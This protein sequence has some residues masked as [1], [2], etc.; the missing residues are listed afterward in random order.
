MTSSPTRSWPTPSRPGAQIAFMNPGG[1]RADLTFANSPGG[2]APGQVT[3]GEAFAVQPFNNLVVTQTFTG[4]QIKDVLEQQFA[5]LRGADVAADPAGVGRVHVHLRRTLA[6]RQPGLDMA[7][8]G[9]PIDPAATYRVTTND[10]L[11][12][13]GDGFTTLTARHEP[14]LRARLRRRRAGGPPEP[15]PG[16]PRADKTASPA[17]LTRSLSR[18]PS[19][20]ALSLS[21]A[22]RYRLVADLDCL[23]WRPAPGMCP[24]EGRDCISATSVWA[25]RSSSCM[26][27]PTSITATC[28]PSSTA[29]PS[30]P[31]HLL[32]PARAGA[33]RRRRA[34]GG[35]HPRVRDG[36]LDLCGATSGLESMAAPR[37]QLGRRAGDGVRHPASRA[38]DPSDLDE[39]RTRLE[40]GRRR[41]PASPATASGLSRVEAMRFP[42][43]VRAFVRETSMST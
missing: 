28:C 25:L 15:R 13:G 18:R 37:A 39:H 3:Y 41:L 6:G 10:F 11:A 31:A 24:R 34:T 4:A 43:G 23:L 7:L 1:I 35:G 22:V 14:G 17:R 19:P 21:S 42:R 29:W 33:V 5:G 9:M 27:V 40:P 20:G 8:N 2:E 32:R 26:A 12:N 30:I 38:R 16:R 36:D